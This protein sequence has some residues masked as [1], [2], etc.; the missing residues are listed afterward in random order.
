MLELNPVTE[1][2]E[3]EYMGDPPESFFTHRNGSAQRLPDGNTLICD[4][5]NGRAFE[6]TREGEIV[7]EWL[8]PLW[9]GKRRIQV[10]RMERIAPGVVERL[11]EKKK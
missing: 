11:L 10:Y 6:V 3:W 7:W 1:R 8:S 4:G 9:K 5:D 2:V